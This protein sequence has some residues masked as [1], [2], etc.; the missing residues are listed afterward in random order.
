MAKDAG[1]LLATPQVTR[2]FGN[3]WQAVISVGG[4]SAGSGFESLAAHH[5]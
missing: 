4:K 3:H 5:H 1:R 2:H